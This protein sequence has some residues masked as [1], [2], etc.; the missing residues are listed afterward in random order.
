MQMRGGHLKDVTALEYYFHKNYYKT[1]SLMAN[2][3]KVRGGK[4][5]KGGGSAGQKDR[6]AAAR[7]GGGRGERV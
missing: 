2:S 6:A 5:G 7:A 4:E 3:C 1:G